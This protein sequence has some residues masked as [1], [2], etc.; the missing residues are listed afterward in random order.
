MLYP[1]STKSSN[2]SKSLG[3]NG[4]L[5]FKI[6]QN[7][8]NMTKQGSVAK[9]QPRLPLGPNAHIPQQS[10]QQTPAGSGRNQGSNKA[11]ARAVGSRK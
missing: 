2:K 7:S 1:G 6:Q 5:T 8:N 3:P 4:K 11:T 10:E 9:K